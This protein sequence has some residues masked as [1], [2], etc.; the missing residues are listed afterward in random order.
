LPKIL[1]PRDNLVNISAFVDANHVGNIVTCHSHRGILLYVQNAL[2]A[3]F[4]KQQNTV[5]G[6]TFGSEFVALQFC[7]DMIVAL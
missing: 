1:E 3:R 2:I 6:S 4:S 7:Q 5:E